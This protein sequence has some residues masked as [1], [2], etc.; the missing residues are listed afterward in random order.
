[1]KDRLVILY[2]I[3]THM[4]GGA[5]KQLFMLAAEMK[6]RGH[7]VHLF[8]V[9]DNGPLAEKYRSINVR[10]HSGKFSG[11]GPKTLRILKL[12]RA[13]FRLIAL[14]MRIQPDVLHGFLPLTNFMIAVSGLLTRARAVITSR[15]A[16]GYHQERVPLWKPMDKFANWASNV[17]TANSQAVA[18]DVKT[19][20]GIAPEKLAVIYNGIDLQVQPPARRVDLR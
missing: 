13:Q 20:D 16:L 10:L 1:M 18:A 12:L 6:S 5:E 15:R 8:T 19:R 17:V 9:D 7:D 11:S 3:G 14:A 2:A 4:L